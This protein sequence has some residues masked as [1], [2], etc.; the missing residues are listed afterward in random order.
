MVT[1]IDIGTDNEVRRAE[2]LEELVLILDPADPIAVRAQDELNTLDQALRK[3]RQTV[4]RYQTR[5]VELLNILRG[6][7]LD[8]EN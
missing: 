6:T 1:V 3:R 2:A 5:K 8:L 7:G 4:E